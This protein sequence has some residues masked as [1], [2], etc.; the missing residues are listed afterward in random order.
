MG[1]VGRPRFRKAGVHV[2][3]PHLL[4]NHSTHGIEMAEEQGAN[5]L[6]TNC[7]P[8]ILFL[9]QEPE[10]RREAGEPVEFC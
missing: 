6:L 7:P 1:D 4:D 8:C 3:Y 2:T 9:E 5:K 10:L